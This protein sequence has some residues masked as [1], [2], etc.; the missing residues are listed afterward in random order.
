MRGV[1]LRTPP[2]NAPEDAADRPGAVIIV[3]VAIAALDI[4]P[5]KP[6]ETEVEDQPLVHEFQRILNEPLKSV[7]LGPILAAERNQFVQ[8]GSPVWRAIDR[9]VSRLGAGS[10]AGF[11]PRPTLHNRA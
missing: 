5:R 4:V 10:F 9:V 7:A 8:V 3:K 6:F 2:G 11:C 1:G